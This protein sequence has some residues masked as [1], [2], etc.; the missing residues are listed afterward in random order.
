MQIR[1]EPEKTALPICNY[2]QILYQFLTFTQNLKRSH[3]TEQNCIWYCSCTFDTFGYIRSRQ[4]QPYDYPHSQCLFVGTD[5]K[6]LLIVI[7]KSPPKFFFFAYTFSRYV[8]FLCHASECRH[9]FPL[10]YYN[11]AEYAIFFWKG[12]SFTFCFLI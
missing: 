11:Y 9:A 7:H 3:K 10:F 12:L 1:A 6:I 2:S 4:C 5:L 8:R